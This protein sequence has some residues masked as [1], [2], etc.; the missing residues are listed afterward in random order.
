MSQL[1]E[2]SGIITPTK[3]MVYARQP[4]GGTVPTP[5]VVSIDISEIEFK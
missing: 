4:D 1:Q 3:H 5:V 2:V